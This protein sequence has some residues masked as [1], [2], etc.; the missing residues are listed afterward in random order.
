MTLELEFLNTNLGFGHQPKPQK[1][2]S[3]QGNWRQGNC[4]GGA[5]WEGDQAGKLSAGKLSAK[6]KSDDTFLKQLL[7]PS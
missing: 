3:R 1:R 5:L 7:R 2:R 4:L 6:A